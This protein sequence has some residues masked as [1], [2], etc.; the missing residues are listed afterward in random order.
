[1]ATK[2]IAALS[3]KAALVPHKI[4][5]RA[6]GAADVGIE[7]KW[8]G[9]CHSDIHQAREEWGPAI[10]PMVPGHEIS[11]VVSRVGPDVTKFKVGDH[12]GVGCFV[13]S[14]RKCDYC[15]A[16]DDQ[17][18]GQGGVQTYN[19]KF[20]FGH[21]SEDGQPTYG[22]YSQYIVVDENYACRIPS[23]LDL[24]GAAPLLCAGITTYSPLMHFG[25]KANHTLG[26]AG[27]GGLGH[28]AV[29][30]GV[31][32]GAKVVVFSRSESKKEEA[33]KGLGATSFVDTTNAAQT[34]AAVNTCDIII[35]CISAKHDV[36]TYLSFLK[37]NGKLVMVGASP[38]PLSVHAFNLIPQRKTIAGSMIGGIRE[39]EEMLEFCGRHNIVCDVEKIGADQVNEAYERT[40]KSD[41]KYRF[42]IDTATIA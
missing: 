16:G 6:L 23:N 37:T 20:K 27:L 3:S 40:I 19:S 29:K 4:D 32:L 2:A 7:I 31:A 15:K 24:A 26:V 17:Y 21:T 22:G 34:A 33:L 8:A 35:D 39:T 38:E 1:M 14:C 36:A 10:F 28:M 13:D 25:L 18:C 30:F 42:V 9:I 5:R 12:V 11:G 41:V